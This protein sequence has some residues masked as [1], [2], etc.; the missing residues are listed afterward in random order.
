MTRKW[1]LL[2][3]GQY[4]NVL[5]TLNPTVMSTLDEKVGEGEIDGIQT[6][7]EVVGSRFFT[8]TVDV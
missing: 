1:V 2:L 5:L 7:D 3:F 4:V 6:F 8:R